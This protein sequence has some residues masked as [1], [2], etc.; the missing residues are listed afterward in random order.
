MGEILW[1]IEGNGLTALTTK[2]RRE[3]REQREERARGRREDGGS[4]K[5][6]KEVERV[7]V[8]Q[9]ALETGDDAIN[10]E[11]LEATANALG[12]VEDEKSAVEV[13]VAEHA[14]VS[15]ISLSLSLSEKATNGWV[16]LW[17]EES[18]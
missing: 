13:A 10:G 11:E 12:F 8:L 5:P 6:L 17:E 15:L 9:E 18:G 14:I 7:R 2:L 1:S 16:R 3:E 4:W